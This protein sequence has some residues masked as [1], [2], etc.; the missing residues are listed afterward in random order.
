MKKWR[1]SVP[2]SRIRG[3]SCVSRTAASPTISHY[4]RTDSVEPHPSSA[5]LH[6]EGLHRIIQLQRTLGNHRVTQLIEAGRL[7]PRGELIGLHPKLAVGAAHDRYEQEADRV[8]QDVLSMPEAPAVV[9]MQD[10]E[11]KKDKDAEVQPQ[12]VGA[13]NTFVTERQPAQRYKNVREPIQAPSAGALA[14]SFEA[15]EDVEAQLNETKARGSS[16]P[17]P[18]RA[19]MEPR[20]GMDFSHVRVH[21]GDAA[22]GM[23]RSID[24]KLLRTGRIFTMAA[25]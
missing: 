25:V 9:L 11:R 17:E 1:R 24:A 19:F 15:G 4:P 2:I 5:P 3:S 7:T 12:P 14:E 13:S 21:T 22:A 6:N 8:A 18:V 20:F 16:L 10:R 23:N